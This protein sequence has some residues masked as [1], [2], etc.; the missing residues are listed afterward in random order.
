MSYAFLAS[1][2]KPSASG[3][4]KPPEI[5]PLHLRPR[6]FFVLPSP[7]AF[8]YHNAIHTS[9]ANVPPL[10]GN[11]DSHGPWG[12]VSMSAHSNHASTPFF[13]TAQECLLPPLA[14]EGAG[15]FGT[16]WKN[17]DGFAFFKAKWYWKA[18]APGSLPSAFRP[19][20]RKGDH[21]LYPCRESAWKA[22]VEP[23]GCPVR[24]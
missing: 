15:G 19:Q 14:R 2:L 17:P 18:T 11:D 7:P 16:C 9:T 12:A 5:S 23:D 4:A 20:A 6:P 24:G 10:R 13:L 8:L 21:D 22:S 1:D 3:E